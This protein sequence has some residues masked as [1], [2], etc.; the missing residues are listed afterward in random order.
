MSNSNLNLKK[1]IFRHGHEITTQVV[2]GGMNSL[3]VNLKN[4]ET[5]PRLFHDFCVTFEE[6]STKE[7]RIWRKVRLNTAMTDGEFLSANP[8]SRQK[9]LRLMAEKKKVAAFWANKRQVF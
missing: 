8:T 1:A 2:C 5:Q 3:C 7:I 6:A 4:G 9:R